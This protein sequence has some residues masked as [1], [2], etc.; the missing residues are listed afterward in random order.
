MNKDFNKFN[1]VIELFSLFPGVG[2]RTAKRYLLYMLKKNSKFLPP[3]IK[4]LEE[5]SQS[6]TTCNNCFQT[7]T[8]NPC[9][10]CSDEKRNKNVICIVEDM[11]SLWAIEDSRSYKGVYHVLGETISATREKSKEKLNLDKLIEKIENKEVEEVILAL[12]M[13]VEGQTTLHYIYEHISSYDIKITT[14]AQGIPIGGE[15]NYLDDITIGKALND[16]K[17]ITFR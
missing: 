10:I 2:S 13:N 1:K 5:L 12:S 9:Y 8:S 17:T 11:S 4:A 15:L 14:L 16:R 6:I 7:S 3:L